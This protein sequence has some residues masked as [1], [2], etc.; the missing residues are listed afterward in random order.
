MQERSK[1][2]R[3]DCS[4]RLCTDFVRAVRTLLS[5]KEPTRWSDEDGDAEAEVCD[6]D[7]RRELRF[8]THDPCC[9]FIILILTVVYYETTIMSGYV[10]VTSGLV[11]QHISSARF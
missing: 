3:T 5:R 11:V 4:C 1:V 9:I 7:A 6:V 2:F 8:P 10:L